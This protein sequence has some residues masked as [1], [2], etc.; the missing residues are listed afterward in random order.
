MIKKMQAERDGKEYRKAVTDKWSSKMVGMILKND[1]YIGTLRQGKYSLAGINGKIVVNDKDDHIV[2]ED[3][4]EAIIDKKTFKLANEILTKRRKENYRGSGQGKKVNTYAG[5]LKCAD[6]GKGMT[7]LNKEKRGRAYT[8]STYNRYGKKYCSTHY[9]LDDDITRHIKDFLRLARNGLENIILRFDKTVQER[10]LKK[11]NYNSVIYRF[12]KDLVKANE[13]L[14]VIMTQKVKEMSANP[15]MRDIISETYEAMQKEKLETVSILKKQIAEFKEMSEKTTELKEDL[16][17]S[18]SVFD[19]IISKD[20]I[21]RADLELI[22]DKILVHEDGGLELLFKHDIGELINVSPEE[23]NRR[24]EVD[25]KEDLLA[26]TI[27][28]IIV[29]KRKYI[30]YRWLKLD[31]KVGGKKKIEIVLRELQEMNIISKNGIDQRRPY[32]V[33]VEL[34]KEAEEYYRNKRFIDDDKAGGLYSN[35]VPEIAIETLMEISKIAGY[36]NINE[37]KVYLA[38]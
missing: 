20:G 6:C 2:I 4:H 24:I 5:F 27:A 35:D 10:L 17:T 36:K 25:R 32:I 8:C 38:V 37:A 9:V 3:N 1:F 7:V 28:K 12:E 34:S 26:D 11:E 21:E 15:E 33:N 30:S 22:I 29:S 14:K 23:F 13:E 31:A 16:K 18:L 19:D